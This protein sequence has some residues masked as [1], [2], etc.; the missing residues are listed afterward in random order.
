MSFLAPLLFTIFVWWAST[1]LVLYLVGRPRRTFRWTLV[2][3]TVV[4]LLAFVGLRASSGMA[5]VGGAYCAFTCTLLVWGWQEV[6]FLL[7]AVTG[8]RRSACP[9]DA[10]G[11]RRAAL[12][13][14]T[15]SHHE[16]ALVV[17]GAG[18]VAATWRQPNQTGLW[19][20]AILWTMRQSAK[21][22]VFLGVRNLSEEFLPVH[23]GYL[24]TYFRRARMNVLFPIVV[25]A[26]TWLAARV[27]Q[28]ASVNGIDA[29][30]AASLTFAATLLSLAILEHWFLVL[31]FPSTPLWNWSLRS[32]AAP[33]GDE[34]GPRLS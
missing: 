25:A 17:L 20:F 1:G 21:L 22:N 6:A 18:V 8:P 3:A 33:V 11:W 28:A 19:T 31:P 15:I 9:G 23:L 2:G 34:L 4:A 13:F 26:S 27:W 29:A 30:T 5:T 12:A 32:R 7:G 16:M 24:Q 10:R 14:Q